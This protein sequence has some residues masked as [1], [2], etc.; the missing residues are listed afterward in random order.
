[1][2]FQNGGTTGLV[3]SSRSL[4]QASTF[5]R[6]VGKGGDFYLYAVLMRGGDA[7]DCERSGD[8]ETLTPEREIAAQILPYDDI[9]GYRKVN[10]QGNF[11]GVPQYLNG[12]GAKIQTLVDEY[13]GGDT[14]NTW[15]T[16]QQLP[17][18]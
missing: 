15:A 14:L 18:V 3:C 12:W 11:V 9:I 2:V 4:Y 7:V 16:A 17:S 1:M 6:A 13:S 10:R 5:A 8:P